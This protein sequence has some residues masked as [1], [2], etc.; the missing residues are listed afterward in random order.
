MDTMDYRND[1]KIYL[2]EF[3]VGEYKIHLQR[4]HIYAREQLLTAELNQKDNEAGS[5]WR[6]YTD[7][8]TLTINGSKAKFRKGGFRASL[9]SVL[10]KNKANISKRWS[11]DEIYEKI[12]GSDDIGPK[13]KMKVYEAS[14]GVTEY[15]ATKTGAKEFLI[16][17]T[18]TV[19]VNPTHH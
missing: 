16:Y 17:D 5:E 10:T 11:W 14:K 9:L 15:I 6:Y 13:E 12:E 2:K 19:K 1:Q 4:V 7:D 8:G 3:N 18:N